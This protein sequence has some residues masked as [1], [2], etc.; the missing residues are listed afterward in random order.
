METEEGR[1]GGREIAH[2]GICLHDPLSRLGGIDRTV[3]EVMRFGIRRV[4]SCLQPA[5][6]RERR[7][8]VVGTRTS[9]VV[10]DDIG[11]VSLVDNGALP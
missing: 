5:R 11:A 4:V 9:H 10:A 1:E 3:G 2:R 6:N 8:D 7:P